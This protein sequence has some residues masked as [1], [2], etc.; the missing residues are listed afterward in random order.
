[1]KLAGIRGTKREYLK[2]R[3]NWLATHS[4]NNNIRELYGGID[5]FKKGYQP[6][7]N[8]VKDEKG[9]LLADSHS[10]SDRWKN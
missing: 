8:L 6:K 7:F 5:E 1:M 9:N 3:I 2:N 4:K 10:V